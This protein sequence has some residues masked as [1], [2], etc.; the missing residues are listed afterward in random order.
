MKCLRFPHVSQNAGDYGTLMRDSIDSSNSQ[1][2]FVLDFG[3]IVYFL[4]SSGASN[5]ILRDLGPLP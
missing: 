3:F 2:K 4:T 5:V 1:N